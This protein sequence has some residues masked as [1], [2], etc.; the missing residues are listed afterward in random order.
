MYKLEVFPRN[1]ISA[2][3]L[4]SG[5]VS[6]EVQDFGGTFENP[7]RCATI[8]MSAEQWDRLVQGVQRQR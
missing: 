1:T 3:V 2:E 4:P 6:I 5:N 7:W 8:E